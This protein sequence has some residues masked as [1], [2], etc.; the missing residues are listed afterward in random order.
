[1]ELA[2]L[3][4]ASVSSTPMAFLYAL[5]DPHVHDPQPG[6]LSLPEFAS[7]TSTAASRIFGLFPRKGVIAVGSDADVVVLDP[8]ARRTISAKTHYSACDSNIFEGW[9]VQ[10]VTV[11]TL[12]RGQV[13]WEVSVP[14]DGLVDWT[15]GKH[16]AAKGRGIYLPRR[17]HG[18]AYDQTS[19]KDL[20]LS[21]IQR[22][23]PRS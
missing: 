14:P 20:A 23:I 18:P 5:F 17:S 3:R 13:V 8:S 22:P 19:R 9:V 12:S 4:T 16:T 10:G 2:A 1:M 7:V 6:R 11:L 15:K 21:Q